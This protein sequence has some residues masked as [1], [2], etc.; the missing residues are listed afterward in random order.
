MC[1]VCNPIYFE[2]LNKEEDKINEEKQEIMNEERI[3]SKA[4][5]IVEKLREH[6]IIWGML[7]FSFRILVKIYRI[8][9]I[10]KRKF[11]SK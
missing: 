1:Q 5:V 9:K 10:I 11:L 6:R 2:V 4:D 7:F 8:M 3:P